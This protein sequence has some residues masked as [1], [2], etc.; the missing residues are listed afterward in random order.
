MTSYTAS[1]IATLVLISVPIATSNCT[2]GA[3]RCA[4]SGKGFE[5]CN[6]GSWVPFE[7]GP[8]TK[9]KELYK[10]YTI[11]DYDYSQPPKAQTKSYDDGKSYGASS[12]SSDYDQKPQQDYGDQHSQDYSSSPPPSSYDDQQHGNY[13]QKRSAEP[14]YSYYNNGYYNSYYRPSSSYYYGKNY[15]SNY[16]KYGYLQKRDTTQTTTSPYSAYSSYDWSK[17]TDYAHHDWNQYHLDC[18]NVGEWKDTEAAPGSKGWSWNEENWKRW[19]CHMIKQY[20]TKHDDK[21]DTS[22]YNKKDNSY[23]DHSNDYHDNGSYGSSSYTDNHP[24]YNDKYDD[25][26]KKTDYSSGYDDKKN[27]YSSGYD[28]KKTDYSSGY[29]DDKKNDY[30]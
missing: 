13:L 16:N 11:C 10:G 28:D 27:D 15:Y 8:G 19:A 20:G 6:W 30:Y 22:D 21:H 3:F 29:G 4:S 2:D 1:L 23:D 7:C 14:T 25:Y 26:S 17:L 24:V 18:K 5:K 9:C 12:W